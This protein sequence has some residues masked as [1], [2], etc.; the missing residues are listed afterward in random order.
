MATWLDVK[1]SSRCRMQDCLQ[2]STD[3]SSEYKKML[4]GPTFFVHK[5][6]FTVSKSKSHVSCRLS[7]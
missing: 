6:N 4:F 2:E 3:F 5:L 1:N 7:E